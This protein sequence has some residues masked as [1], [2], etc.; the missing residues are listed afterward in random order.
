MENDTSPFVQRLRA[1]ITNISKRIVERALPQKARKVL[2]DF[3]VAR[4]YLATFIGIQI[5]LGAL[6]LLLLLALLLAPVFISLVGAGLFLVLPLLVAFWFLVTVS[7]VF[8]LSIFFIWQRIEGRSLSRLT[9]DDMTQVIPGLPALT[10]GENT[11]P[12]WEGDSDP[13]SV[14]LPSPFQTTPPD[15]S[16]NPTTNPTENPT[17]DTTME[18]GRGRTRYSDAV[19]R[20]LNT[21]LPRS[22]EFVEATELAKTEGAPETEGPGAVAEALAGDAGGSSPERSTFVVEGTKTS[23]DLTAFEGS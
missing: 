12:E 6:P 20:G 18:R 21:N 2:Q 3:A 14:A 13:A 16:P 7:L 8:L 19:K 5:L 17:M 11:E 15:P 1:S 10:P 22:G 4:P 23:E 9:M